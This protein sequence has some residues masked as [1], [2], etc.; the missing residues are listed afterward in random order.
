MAVDVGVL[1][2][3]V[4]GLTTSAVLLVLALYEL[5]EWWDERRNTARSVK[6]DLAHQAALKAWQLHQEEIDSERRIRQ[7][8]RTAVEQIVQAARHNYRPDDDGVQDQP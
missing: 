8:T 1:I 3:L 5:L 2:T 6:R 4:L 7:V